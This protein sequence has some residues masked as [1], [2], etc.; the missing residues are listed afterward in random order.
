M[1]EA[2][3]SMREDGGGGLEFELDTINA[4]PWLS[5]VQLFNHDTNEADEEGHTSTELLRSIEYRNL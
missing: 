5:F 1:K 3:E 4:A 2:V